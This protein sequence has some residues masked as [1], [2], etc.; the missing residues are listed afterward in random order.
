[1]RY[2][3]VSVKVAVAPPSANCDCAVTV[4]VPGDD[5]SVSVTEA[6][7]DEL[8]VAITLLPLVVPLERVPAEVVKK[9]PAPEAVPPDEPGLSVTVSGAESV[10]PRVP[11]CPLPLVVSVAGGLPTMIHPP[12]VWGTPLTVAFTV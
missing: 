4:T 2:C 6:T 7:P 10:V 5:G 3:A 11:D 12:C 1:M 9:M 8:V